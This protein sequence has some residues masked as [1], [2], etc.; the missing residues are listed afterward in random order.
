MKKKKTLIVMVLVGLLLV[1]ATGCVSATA[2]TVK[3][4]S[5]EIETLYSVVGERPITGSSVS[6]DTNGSKTELTYGNG[7]VSIGDVNDYI[8]K[9]VNEQG[10]LVT[11]QA[12]NDG[13]GQTYQIGKQASED[14]KIFLVDFY[15]EDGGNTVI[16]Y[17]VTAGTLTAK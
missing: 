10:F 2:P 1:L 9:L 14:G 16:T 7:S 6:T 11:R 8:S 12:E 3:V 4:G 5:E 13:T 15:F 17:Q